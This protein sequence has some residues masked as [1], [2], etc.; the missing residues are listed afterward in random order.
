MGTRTGEVPSERQFY[1][2]SVA[3]RDTELRAGDFRKCI[4]DVRARDFV[5][6][7]PPYSSVTRPTY[8]EYGY[9]AFGLSDL[10]DLQKWLTELDRRGAYFLLSYANRPDSFR[11]FSVWNCTQ[12]FVRRH[13]AGFS[14]HR[15][16]AKELLV[17]N[18]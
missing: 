6:L 7:D 3:L 12:L 10:P 2:C 5:Y 9:G 16:F 1:R 4:K 15:V 17:S 18:Y 13:V 8:G 14:T 11:A